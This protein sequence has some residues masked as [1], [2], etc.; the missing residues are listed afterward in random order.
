M[1]VYDVKDY[2]EKG[3]MNVTYHND[4]LDEIR[5]LD[6]DNKYRKELLSLETDYNRIMNLPEIGSIETLREEIEE[7]TSA[8]L[9]T[10]L[11]EYYKN[12]VIS[13]IKGIN[14]LDALMGSG[15]TSFIFNLLNNK[16]F[17]DNVDEE[18]AEYAENGVITKKEAKAIQMESTPQR[19]ICIVPTLDEIQRYKK[20]LPFIETFEPTNFSKKEQSKFISKLESFK[21][22]IKRN[23]NIVTTH[24]L[25][26]MLDNETMELLRTSDY[27]LVIDE[28]LNVVEPFTGITNKSLEILFDTNLVT[29]DKDDFLI[30]NEEDDDRPFEFNNIKRLCRLNSLMVYNRNEETKKLL[31][32]NFPFPF[33]S[34]F[35]TCYICTYLWDGS[36]QKSYFDLHNIQYHH[37]TISNGEMVEFNKRHEINNR[38]QLKELINIYEDG[39]LNDIG[40]P[41]RNARG[42]STQPLTKSWY[43]KQLKAY[44]E[45][46]RLEEADGEPRIGGL[47]K[48]SNRI[49]NYLHNV[50]NAK[51]SEIMWTCYQFSLQDNDNDNEL[52]K[53]KVKKFKNILQKKGYT[54]DSCFAPCN[55]KGTN[56][57]GDRFNLVY[58]INFY[59]QPHIANFFRFNGIDVNEDLYSLSYLVQWIFRSRIRNGKPIN[60]YIPSLRMRTLLQKWLDGEI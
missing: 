56:A 58:A 26:R 43:D 42:K 40:E 20:E 8:R 39:S 11:R 12:K 16:M 30:W 45:D 52:T 2:D 54:A 49:Y 51:T 13:E 37:M 4:L 6:E 44:E 57:Y 17:Y 21:D 32:W 33:F 31:L 1:F 29:T 46:K 15:K 5:S 10:L 60:I 35:K 19:F 9:V 27:M 38:K 22:L 47:V 3:N 7:K 28:E 18:T 23:R 34:L 24:A 59:I 55:C 41:Y 50:V 25:I 14:I 53:K 36:I 48:L